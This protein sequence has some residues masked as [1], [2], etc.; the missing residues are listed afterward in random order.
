MSSSSLD[1]YKSIWIGCFP[2][3]N[4]GF[5]RGRRL[6]PLGRPLDSSYNFMAVHKILKR[7]AENRRQP[8]SQK[9]GADKAL[10]PRKLPGPAGGRDRIMM[11]SQA[12]K[13]A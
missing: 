2:K 1:F 13:P 9:I 10:N 4:S 8:E 12:C 3:K 5:R 11:S 6:L 7:I